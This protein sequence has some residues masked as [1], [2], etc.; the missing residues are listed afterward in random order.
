MKIYILGQQV[1][2]TSGDYRTNEKTVNGIYLETVAVGN[3]TFSAAQ[4][5]SLQV[6]A[7]QCPLSGGE[8]VLRARDMLALAQDAP[9][10]YNNGNT[11]GNALRPSQNRLE[12]LQINDFVQVR[13]NP[14]SENIVVDY[15]LSEGVKYQIML[16]SIFG[17]V[18]G[19]FPLDGNEGVTTIPINNLP[20][21]IYWYSVTGDKGISCPGKLII[22]R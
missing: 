11:C 20:E 13:P 21:G 17:Q 15:S 2:I 4:L 5:S 6:V 3:N 10:F 18:V 16:V 9:T 14:A 22:H 1:N 7:A 19:I 8:A 12:Q